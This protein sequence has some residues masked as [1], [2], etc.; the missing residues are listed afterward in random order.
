MNR[1][2]T[3]AFAIVWLAIA[4]F[5]TQTDLVQNYKVAE[6][7][8]EGAWNFEVNGKNVI[9]HSTQPMDGKPSDAEY[10]VIVIHGAGGGRTNPTQSMA[11]V[12]G[13]SPIKGK[14]IVLGPRFSEIGVVAQGE[15]ANAHIW[16]E[17]WKGGMDST[18]T[19]LS[20]FDVI[21]QLYLYLGDRVKF[22]KLKRI[23]L[24]GHSAGG[25]FTCRYIAVGKLPQTKGISHAFI[26]ANPS[27]YLYID[28]RRPVADGTFAEVAPELNIW[29]FGMG[30]SP[31]YAAGI[32]PEAAL[33]NYCARNTLFLCGDRDC[34]RGG[35]LAVG[36]AADA[37]GQNR[38]ERFKN[39]SRYVKLFPEWAK[40]CCFLPVPS[41]GHSEFG[42]YKHPAVLKIIS[43]K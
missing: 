29:F 9:C 17:G 30:S 36:S 6:H 12:I 4:G 40:S 7:P 37:Q 38:F 34:Q 1:F 15:E 18:T 35:G 16:D 2:L 39:F 11:E 28:A 21:D 24:A 20:S 13:K 42:C 23:I 25:Q 31:R 27:T 33:A 10:A 43:G 22:P 8:V 41:V 14:T 19:G 3:C 32:T 5:A 26:I